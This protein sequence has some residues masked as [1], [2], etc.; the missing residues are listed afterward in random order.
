MLPKTFKNKTGGPQAREQHHGRLEWELVAPW[1]ATA[2]LT[3]GWAMAPN[4]AE[5]N[6]AKGNRA[7]TPRDGSFQGGGN[8]TNEAVVVPPL[9]SE[10]GCAARSVPDAEARLQRN[11]N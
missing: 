3:A 11:T 2:G 10:D 7:S 1:R 9:S 6:R 5:R 4:P 8:V